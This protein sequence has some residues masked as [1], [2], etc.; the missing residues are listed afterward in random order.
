MGID[1]SSIF[2]SILLGILCGILGIIISTATVEYFNLIEKITYI[3]SEREIYA[4]K[5]ISGI[6]GNFYLF[7]G[8]VGDEYQ[9]R[10][11]INT[12]KGKQVET[13]SSEQYDVYI[14]EGNYKPKVVCEKIEYTNKIFNNWFIFPYKDYTYTI[15]VPN[16]T[17]LNNYNIDLE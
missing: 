17:I 14:K 11:V 4:L 15:Y 3:E 9:Y 1:L 12:P 7:G 10:Y 8:N 2:I 6:E 5:D 13:V 16:N